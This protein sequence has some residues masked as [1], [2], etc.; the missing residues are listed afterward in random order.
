MYKTNFVV[1]IRDIN[2][3][4]HLDHLSLLGYLHET[5]VRYLK[6]LGR[7]EDNVDGLGSCLIVAN[8]NCNYKKECF[9]NDVLDV[10]LELVRES[11]LRL[12]LRYIVKRD[13]IVVATADITIAFIGINKKLVK[14]PVDFR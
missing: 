6:L 14:V 1:T 13:C 11:E 12:I 2:Y 7:S 9:Y 4:Q 8:I 10:E 5:R 3:G